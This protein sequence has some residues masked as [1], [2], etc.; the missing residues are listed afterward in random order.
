MAER[1]YFMGID[2]GGSRTVAVVV[3]DKLQELGRGQ[4][5]PANYHNVGLESLRRT[6]WIAA[7]QA[8]KGA[9]C[10]FGDLLGL[11]CGLAG[12]GRPE[13]RDILR[14]VVSEVIPIA[15]LILTHDAEIGLVGG[16]GRREGVVLTCGTGTM[17][18][19]VNASGRD[20]RAGGWGPTL[21][22]EGSGY[23]IGLRGLRA[24]VRGYDRRAPATILG[25]RILAVLGLS[26]ME[27]LVGWVR[28]RGHVDEIAALAPVVG[29]CARDGDHVA[30]AILRQAGSEVAGLALAVLQELGMER[31]PCE[32]VLVGGT[33]RHQP[34]VVQALRE[35]LARSVTL[36]HLAWPRREPVLGAALLALKAWEER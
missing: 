16:T 15:P 8:C 17:A 13:D 7:D 5:G 26:Q 24:A 35:D 19:G 2:G 34:L 1:S 22:D 33:F 18:Y 28:E 21:G 25:V 32:I 3:D 23:W 20:A 6:L 10:T 9:G 12:A 30:Q 29:E 36:A 31:D 11:C 14:R 27:E 4:A